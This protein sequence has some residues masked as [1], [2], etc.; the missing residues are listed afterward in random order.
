[1]QNRP[2]VLCCL[3]L[4][5]LATARADE[6]SPPGVVVAAHPLATEAGVALL[7]AGGSALPISLALL[8]LPAALNNLLKADVLRLIRG[9]A[10]GD[11]PCIFN[12][13]GLIPIVHLQALNAHRCAHSSGDFQH[14]AALAWLPLG[15]R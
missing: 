12:A 1:M 5:V 9:V 10:E 7:E 14:A 13:V 11:A 15:L 8:D 3:M 2:I 6:R 4:L